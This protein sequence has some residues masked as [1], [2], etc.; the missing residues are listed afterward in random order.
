MKQRI[1]APARRLSFAL[2]SGLA[3]VVVVT[4]L[5]APSCGVGV[6]RDL[7]A[8]RG[9]G[10]GGGSAGAGTGGLLGGGGDDA[11]TDDHGL[12]A[13]TFDQVSQCVIDGIQLHCCPGTDTGGAGSYAMIGVLVPSNL[14]KCAE[15]VEAL[16]DAPFVDGQDGSGPSTIRQG[17]HA[18][19]PNSLMVGFHADRDDLLCQ[20]LAKTTVEEVDTNSWDSFSVHVCP[21]IDVP[22]PP[23]I[24]PGEAMSGIDV[25]NGRILCAR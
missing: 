4:A 21:P 6:S 14:F 25:A 7:S 24:Y 18:C 22:D 13:V 16:I 15:I 5:A 3:A 12:G 8:A 2:A 19:P 20:T 23:R 1:G 9:S 10:G 17:M 11:G